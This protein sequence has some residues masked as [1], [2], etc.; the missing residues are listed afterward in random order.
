VSVSEQ[1]DLAEVLGNRY[2]IVAKLGAGAFG[3]VYKAQ[4]TLLHRTVA[5]KRIRMDAFTDEGQ[6]EEVKE[7]F[8]REAKVAAQLSHPNIVTIHDIHW[9]RDLSFIVMEF[10][11]GQTLQKLLSGKRRLTLSETLDVLGP[12]A[13]ALDHAHQKKVVHRDIK[14]ANIMIEPSG[15]PK[16]T[17]FGIAKLESAGTTN[18][19]AT[20]S[21][22]GTPNYMSPEQARGERELDGRSDLF[23][24]GCILYECLAGEKPFRGDSVTAVLMKIL[25][26]EAPSLDCQRAGLP[27]ALQ[28]VVKRALAKNLADRYGS[29]RELVDA[30]RAAAASAPTVME[31]PTLGGTTLSPAG[32]TPETHRQPSADRTEVAPPPLPRPATARIEG[33]P[34]PSSSVTLRRPAVPQ[35]EPRRSGVWILGAAAVLVLAV[36]AGGILLIKN[37]RAA[38]TSDP[39]RAA[40]NQAPTPNPVA[41]PSLESSE[42]A[43]AAG[44]AEAQPQPES[45]SPVS[46]PG[47]P[48]SAPAPSKAAPTAPTSPAKPAVEA[49][50]ANAPGRLERARPVV[51]P[52]PPETTEGMEEEPVIDGSDAGRRLADAYRKGGSTAPRAYGGGRFQPRAEVL[53]FAANERGAVQRLLKIAELQALYQK[54]H[55]AFGTADQLLQWRAAEARALGLHGRPWATLQGYRFRL[56]L[57]RQDFFA[58]FAVP[59]QYGSTGRVSLYIDSEGVVRGADKSG[60][61]A[62]ATDPPH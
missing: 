11:E 36:G 24:L 4:D 22:L 61:P 44:P 26:E 8:L 35:P 47:P 23:S 20:G 3:E 41:S 45:S 2:R 34:K 55:G 1:T 12:V 62:A 58:A 31:A 13:D 38:D 19:T 14:P 59:V 57:P 60:A 48:P 6:L 18:L 53:R 39:A 7:R 27:L 29:G 51:A 9:S 56:E 54:E 33:Q 5:I 49:A 43:P 17:D 52:P 28:P 15:R 16:V 50:P 37:R 21:I 42:P 30:L 25:T 10:I 46:E 40:E 32:P